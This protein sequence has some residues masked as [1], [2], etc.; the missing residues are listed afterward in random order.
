MAHMSCCDI[1]ETNRIRLVLFGIRNRTF[2]P[3]S[4]ATCACSTLAAKVETAAAV[5]LAKRAFLI[6]KG[7]L[8][9]KSSSIFK[10][11]KL[12][13]IILPPKSCLLPRHSWRPELLDVACLPRRQTDSMCVPHPIYLTAHLLAALCHEDRQTTLYSFDCAPAGGALPAIG[14]AHP[15]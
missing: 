8:E 3:Y 9:I 6:K 5:C 11:F 2:G 4:E 10:N 13:E 7:E 14:A 12:S 1:T 15:P